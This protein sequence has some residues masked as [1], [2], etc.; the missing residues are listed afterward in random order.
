MEKENEET[1]MRGRERSRK[2]GNETKIL[3]DE[4]QEKKQGGRKEEDGEEGDG[5]M[6]TKGFWANFDARMMSLKL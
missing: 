4:N 6:G 5:R 3:E 2:E 1:N